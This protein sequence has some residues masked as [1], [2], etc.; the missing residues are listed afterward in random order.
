MRP[1]YALGAFIPL[2]L[3]LWGA[4]A[5][6]TLVFVTSALAIVPAAALMETPP[7]SSRRARGPGSAAS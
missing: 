6:P 3:A 5:A 1:V 4:D 7:S 2:A